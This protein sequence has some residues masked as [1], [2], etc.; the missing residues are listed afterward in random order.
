MYMYFRQY[1][2]NWFTLMKM[3]SF[4]MSVFFAILQFCITNHLFRKYF[5]TPSIWPMNKHYMYFQCCNYLYSVSYGYS[6]AIDRLHIL[7]DRTHHSHWII[8]PLTSA[9]KAIEVSQWFSW[10]SWNH[11]SFVDN[12]ILMPT[13]WYYRTFKSKFNEVCKTN[14]T[15]RNPNYWKAQVTSTHG[16]EQLDQIAHLSFFLNI[17]Y[18][19]LIFLFS[20]RAI[21]TLWQNLIAGYLLFVV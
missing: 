4:S 15:S 6:I 8:S 3:K 11:Y 16:E 20:L 7:N 19:L 10:L 5:S 21:H 1:M 12:W 13:Y 2:Y 18:V 9:G 17:L 14:E